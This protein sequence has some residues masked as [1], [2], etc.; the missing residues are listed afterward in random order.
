MKNE[1]DKPWMLRLIILTIGEQ[2]TQEIVL[3]K[4]K[5]PLKSLLFLSLN[6]KLEVTKSLST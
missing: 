4:K 5:K 6:A 1:E 2:S 3:K